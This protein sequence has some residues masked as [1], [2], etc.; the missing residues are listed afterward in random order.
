MAV[1][2]CADIFESLAQTQSMVLVLSTLFCRALE[3]SVC[4]FTALV[5]FYKAFLATG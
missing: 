5:I 4:I 1:N 2:V 3:V